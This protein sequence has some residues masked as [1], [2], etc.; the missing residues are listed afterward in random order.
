[1]GKQTLQGLLTFSC[2]RYKFCICQ[3]RKHRLLLKIYSEK[4]LKGRT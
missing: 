4:V 2:D 3:T 1:M